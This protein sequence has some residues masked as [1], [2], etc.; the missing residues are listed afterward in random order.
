VSLRAVRRAVALGFTLALCVVR[1]W[2]GHLRGPMTLER[3]ALW[4]RDSARM[5]M[6]SMGIQLRVEGTPP[7]HGMV[8]AN[9]LS[10]LD[11][12]FLSAPMPCFFVAKAEIDRWPFFG[13]AARTGGT[14]FLD[15]ASRASAETV[16]RTISERLALPVPIL[17]FPEGTTTDGSHMLPFRTRLI[18]PVT[19]AGAPIIAACVRYVLEDGTPERELC[20]Y[21]NA[22][23][24]PHLWKVLGSAGFHA[25]VRFGEPR[26]YP[27]RRMAA[28]VT[29]AE[30][31]AMRKGNEA[32][33]SR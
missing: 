30:I 26:V 29:H 31:A 32:V 8:V 3:R 27:D 25:E 5:V 11:I 28:D 13:K 18:D 14:I 23:F 2:L 22:A 15:R 16:V 33:V 7:T 20:W 9:H 10:Y 4:L 6:R 1:F 12:V 17:L 19:K 21:G 24:L